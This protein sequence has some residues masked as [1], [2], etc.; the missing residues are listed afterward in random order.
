MLVLQRC[1][2]ATPRQVRSISLFDN[3]KKIL[4]RAAPASPL[5]SEP[6]L[7]S[8][9]E[10][11]GE[12]AASA[13]N[14]EKVG[15]ARQSR[16]I[17]FKVDVP[18]PLTGDA[19][20]SELRAAFQEVLGNEKKIIESHK[21]RLAQTIWEK[22]GSRVPDF[23]LNAATRR[24]DLVSFFTKDHQRGK[25]RLNLLRLDRV[26]MPSNVKVL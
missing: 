13:T 17:G 23:V 14:I 22:T 18:Q 3:V 15:S 24:E 26:E 6:Q 25:G 16:V 11:P 1:L 10:L 12:K 4:G 5:P 7:Q 2:L 21:L 8:S 19:F 20:N 9:G